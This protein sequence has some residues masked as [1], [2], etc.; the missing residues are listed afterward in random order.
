MAKKMHLKKDDTV[1][2]IT[3]KDAGKKG[4]VLPCVPK[5]GRVYRRQSQCGQKTYQTHPSHPAGRHRG[6]RS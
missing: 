3:G 6:K 4:K 2:V 5:S 1:V